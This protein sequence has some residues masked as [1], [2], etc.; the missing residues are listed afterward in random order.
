MVHEC[1]T[2]S[3]QQLMTKFA[4][5]LMLFWLEVGWNKCA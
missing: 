1:F 5:K 3:G 2:G 4:H